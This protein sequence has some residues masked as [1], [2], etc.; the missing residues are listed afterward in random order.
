[1]SKTK[2]ATE[3]M[4]SPNPPK[5]TLNDRKLVAAIEVLTRDFR[6]A[7]EERLHGG[8]TVTVNFRDGEATGN[9]EHH[10]HGSLRV[11]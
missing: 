1:M 6:S 4:N 5:G 7:E 9:I 8:V 11:A 2:T 3:P 10:R